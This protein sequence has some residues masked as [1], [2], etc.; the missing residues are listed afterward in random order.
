MIVFNFDL[1]AD[2]HVNNTED[3]LSV[4][5]GSE[6]LYFNPTTDGF[7]VTNDWNNRHFTLVFDESSILYHVTREDIDDRQSGKKALPPEE[8]VAE[9]YSYIRSLALPQPAE[10]LQRS[11]DFVGRLNMERTKSYLKEE[12]MIRDTDTGLVVDHERCSEFVE[13]LT[14][15]PSSLGNF[16]QEAFIP[17]PIDKVL[18]PESGENVYFYP[19]PRE[20]RMFFPFPN[21]YVGVT[22]AREVLTFAEHARGSQIIDH[23]LRA[24]STSR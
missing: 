17:V 24:V 22:T 10:Q 1:G 13:S 7:S 6:S 21:G 11:L 5:F 9:L 12:G 18:D 3:N 14:E 8:F 23:V 20:I 19:T 4:R 15:N 16:Y 2:I